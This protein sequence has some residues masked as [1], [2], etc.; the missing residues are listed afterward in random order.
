MTST[1]ARLLPALELRAR[2]RSTSRAR[3]PAR[4][5]QVKSIP[6]L[7]AFL[8]A[9]W[10]VSV[11]DA[12]TVRIVGQ[13]RVASGVEETGGASVKVYSSHQVLV[14]ST[15]TDTRGQFY[16]I[17][18]PVGDYTLGVTKSGYVPSLQPLKISFG[19]TEQYVTVFLTPQK[20]SANSN[21]RAPQTVEAAELA[22]PPK[23]RGQFEKGKGALRKKKYEES[24][25][26]LKSVTDAQP[27]FALGYEVLGVAHY[28]AG[29][30]RE[31]ESAF[32]QA[33]Q[34]DPRRS[35]CFF[36]LGLI[37]YDQGRYQES[38]GLLRKGLELNPQSWF[39][40]YQS[41]LTYFALEDYEASE[42]ELLRARGLD[43]SFTEVHVRLGNVHLRR[44][45]PAMALR[46]FEDYLREDPKGRFRERVRRVV[47]EM[48]AAGIPPPS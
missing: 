30:M 34:L 26:L 14:E 12:Q 48:R 46:E 43:P 42:K 36:Q 5:R 8:S 15:V 17:G 11:A 47:E 44:G 32:E 21:G 37:R 24:I 6:A 18:I 20:T 3:G 40:H 27:Q 45:N 29:R 23:V 41:G 31:A 16:F 2:S 9:P 39:G 22:L 1:G 10:I 13:V 19:V 4:F 38:E 28:R 7:L 25:R 35:E 33:L